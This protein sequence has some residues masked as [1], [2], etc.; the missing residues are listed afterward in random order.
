MVSK[1]FPLFQE[2]I[3]VCP[4]TISLELFG[5]NEVVD[6]VTACIETGSKQGLRNKKHKMIPMKLRMYFFIK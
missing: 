3:F 4:T 2:P 5:L 6:K 1:N